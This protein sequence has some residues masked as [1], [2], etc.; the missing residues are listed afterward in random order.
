MTNAPRCNRQGRALTC[1]GPLARPRA[2]YYSSFYED[3]FRSR[4]TRSQHRCV[5]RIRAR[6]SWCPQ[7]G[8]DA[9]RAQSQPAGSSRPPPR[10]WRTAAR[11]RVRR[12]P[13]R[14]SL[15]SGEATNPQASRGGGNLGAPR[16]ARR[17]AGGRRAL[18][19]R[20]LDPQPRLRRRLVA[21]HL[22][23]RW[24]GVDGVTVRVLRNVLV[25]LEPDWATWTGD[26]QPVERRPRADSLPELERIREPV[27]EVPDG[28]SEA[29]RAPRHR[30]RCP[31]VGRIDPEIVERRAGLPGEEDPGSQAETKRVRPGELQHMSPVV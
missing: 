8:R 12:H 15:T 18:L 11:G 4:R 22:P 6:L 27:I 9:R 19:E 10:G 13:D 20:E 7:P 21:P 23:V 16:I 2:A 26:V 3:L 30:L 28:G 31:D 5:R 25:L 17:D 29:C 14:C 1:V 24:V